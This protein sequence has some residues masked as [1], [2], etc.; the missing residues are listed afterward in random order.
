MEKT[1]ALNLPTIDYKTY[2]IKLEYYK[3]IYNGVT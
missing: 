2:K 1:I 3:K